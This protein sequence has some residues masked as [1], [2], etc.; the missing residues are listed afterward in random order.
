MSR[1]PPSVY[2]FA[3]HPRVSEQVW[4][5]VIGYPGS[6]EYLEFHRKHGDRGLRYHRV[7]SHAVPLHEKR[8]YGPADIESK[9]YEH[10]QHF[11]S[12]VRETL[13]NTRLKPGRAGVVVAPVDAELFGHWWFEGQQF[14][15]NVI[16]TL[17]HDKTVNL[18]TSDQALE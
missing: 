6:G 15:R 1:A 17:A 8:P 10:S 3:R 7:T 16:L 5:S 13:R 9:L 11:C 12:I 2:A 14:L 18:V 4:S